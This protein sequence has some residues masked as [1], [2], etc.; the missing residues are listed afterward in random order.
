MGHP[1]AFVVLV[2]GPVPDDPLAVAGVGPQRLRLARDVV[3]D[4]RVGGVEDGLGRPEVLVQ[5]DGGGVGEGLLEVEDVGDVRPPEPVHRLVAVP[6][7]G[8]VAVPTGQQDGQRV[9]HPVGVLVLVD[10]DVGEAGPVVLE[11]VAVLPEEPHGVEQQVVEVHGVGRHHP[12]LVLV[13]HVGDPPV[14]DGGGGGP[15]LLGTELCGLGLA[16]L[17]LDGAGRQL[18]GVDVH[19]PADDLDEPTGVGI[20]IDGEGALV[21]EAVPVGPEDADAGRVEGRHP[22]ARRPGADQLGHPACASPRPPCW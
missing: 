12:L 13:E 9:L 7:H 16:D 19:L 14:E 22:H 5:D 20:V 3:G 6:H 17:A 8:D 21:A 15:V 18:F 2:L 4:H 11:H 10:Q 1:F